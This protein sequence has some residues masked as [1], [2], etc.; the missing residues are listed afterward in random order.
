MGQVFFGV[1]HSNQMS[2]LYVQMVN[3]SRMVV[4]P[5]L[6]QLTSFDVIDPFPTWEE[7]TFVRTFNGKYLTIRPIYETLMMFLVYEAE[8]VFFSLAL[9]GNAFSLGLLIYVIAARDSPIIK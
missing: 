2:C 4:G 9:I 3:G 7:R 5:P 1:D 8:W 6:A